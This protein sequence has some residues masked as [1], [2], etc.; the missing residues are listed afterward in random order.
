[1]RRTPTHYF[2][3]IAADHSSLSDARGE[4]DAWLRAGAR[5]LD[6]EQANDIAVIVTE[7]AA[8]VVDHTS[9]PWVE[10]TVALADDRAT[11]EVAHEGSAN[12]IPG[13]PEWGPASGK[14]RGH[15]LR[16]VRALSERVAVTGDDS[17][18]AIRCEL[19]FS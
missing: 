14:S 7:L 19:R 4:L 16:L 10:I 12:R 6:A 18:A 3:Q 5:P 1:M 13:V 8:N 17:H 9:A 11:I 15:G 2:D